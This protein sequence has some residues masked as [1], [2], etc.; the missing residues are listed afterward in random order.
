MWYEPSLL[1]KGIYCLWYLNFFLFI[2]L[3]FA[4]K[5][6]ILSN[7]FYPKK[8]SLLYLN[9]ISLTLMIL[10][11]SIEF[12]FY[13]NESETIVSFQDPKMDFIDYLLISITLSILPLINYFLIKKTKNK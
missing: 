3:L 13:N 6:Y 7:F 12:V 9:F 1:R 2:I 10:L 11:V 5:F 4:K 8:K